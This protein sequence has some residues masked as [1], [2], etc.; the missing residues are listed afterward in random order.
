M[1]DSP[2]DTSSNIKREVL[3]SCLVSGLLLG[4]GRNPL[5]IA[6]RYTLS[7]RQNL[8]PFAT[9][10]TYRYPC[11]SL[12][13]PSSVVRLLDCPIRTWSE[14]VLATTGATDKLEL[15]LLPYT[16][17]ATISSRS[18]NVQHSGEPRC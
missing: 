7:R 3:S 12:K 13:K 6:I 15:L 4:Q 10:A 17:P 1:R 2:F 11:G 16:I 18:P 8:S 14:S 5:F 9:Y